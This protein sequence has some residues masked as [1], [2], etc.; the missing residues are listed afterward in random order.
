MTE[1]HY[2]EMFQSNG[3]NQLINFLNDEQ[4]LFGSITEAAAKSYPGYGLAITYLKFSKNIPTLN[5][6]HLCNQSMPYDIQLIDTDYAIVFDR[7]IAAVAMPT[8]PG[9]NKSKK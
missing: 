4:K 8:K 9:K 1:Y 2:H 5:V 7:P 3:I 6:K